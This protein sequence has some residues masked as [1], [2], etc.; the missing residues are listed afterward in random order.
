ML[1]NLP[2]ERIKLLISDYFCDGK[3]FD[4]EKINQKILIEVTNNI[5][6]VHKALHG[7]GKILSSPKV[8]SFQVK[9]HNLKCFSKKNH[10]GEKFCENF[11]TKTFLFCVALSSTKAIERYPS[12]ARRYRSS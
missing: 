6:L 2:R 4:K 3:V 7:I 5:Y 12:L 9:I 10:V 11:S 8:L 1:Q